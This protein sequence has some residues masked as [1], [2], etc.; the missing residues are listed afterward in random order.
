MAVATYANG[1]L[2]G[3][4]VFMSG[5]ECREQSPQTISISRRSPVLG[6]SVSY[7]KVIPI[8]GLKPKSREE[9]GY[10]GVGRWTRSAQATGSKI[11]YLVGLFFLLLPLIVYAVTLG[12]YFHPNLLCGPFFGI[13]MLSSGLN[14]TRKLFKYGA[15]LLKLDTE[16]EVGGN[17]SGIIRFLK[18]LRGNQSIDVEVKLACYEKDAIKNGDYSSR[19]AEYWSIKQQIRVKPEGRERVVLFSF[20]IPS[21]LP[22]N[23]FP[24]YYWRLELRGTHGQ[25]SLYRSWRMPID[26]TNS[27]RSE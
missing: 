15:T 12:N 6:F 27:D 4:I 7:K 22:V 19:D 16:P 5:K 20:D 13:C 18:P 11:Q 23:D 26:S 10:P 8:P 21:G 1:V 14:T 25:K 17:A 9:L 24:C 2:Q 3:R